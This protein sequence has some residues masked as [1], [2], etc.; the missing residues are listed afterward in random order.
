MKRLLMAE[1]WDQYARGVLPANCSP[2]Q[3]QEMRRAF[4]T[5][6][7]A[8]LWAIIGAFSPESEP[9]A[10]DLKVMEDVDQELRDFA[11]A[12]RQGRA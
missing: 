9:T 12:V 11:E 6:A 8:I 10:E 5:G 7:Q 3:K 1:Q 2:V 4:Y